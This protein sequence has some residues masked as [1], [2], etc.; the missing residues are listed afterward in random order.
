MDRRE[1]AVPCQKLGA[2]VMGNGGWGMGGAG[3]W[4]DGKGVDG[5]APQESTGSVC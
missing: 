2:A 3:G 1:D 4:G 5:T